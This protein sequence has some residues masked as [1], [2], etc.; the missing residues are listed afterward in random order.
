MSQENR[1]IT[2][3]KRGSHAIVPAKADVLTEL[4]RISDL[5]LTLSKRVAQL[6]DTVGNLKLPESK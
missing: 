1:K 6:A 5:Q 3:R 2:V 4:K